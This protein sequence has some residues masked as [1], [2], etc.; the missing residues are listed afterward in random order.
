MKMKFPRSFIAG[1]SMTNNGK[2]V[3][4]TEAT[5]FPNRL[6]MLEYWFANSHRAVDYPPKPKPTRWQRLRSVFTE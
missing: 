3:V 4:F 5:L 2:A 1:D 6:A